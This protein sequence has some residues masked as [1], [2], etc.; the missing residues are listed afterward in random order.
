[1][2]EYSKVNF[3]SPACLIHCVGVLNVL[4]GSVAEIDI[5]PG[6]TEDDNGNPSSSALSGRSSSFDAPIVSKT[7][8]V[9]KI[10]NN[11][12]YGSNASKMKKNYYSQQSSTTT[13]SS[14]MKPVQFER[15][16]KSLDINALDNQNPITNS[17]SSNSFDKVNK[18]SN[19]V[20][21]SSSESSL[22]NHQSS[23][24]ETT[25]LAITTYVPYLELKGIS[26]I[27]MLPSCVD[28]LNREASLSDEEFYEVFG[29]EK[30]SFY[31]LPT[32]KRVNQK[33]AKL[34]F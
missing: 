31:K 22:N 15:K 4:E 14:S 2:Y 12:N 16:M 29:M 33:K 5:K 26:E 13:T 19:T 25:E 6:M 28:P 7:E 8:N 20:K 18:S 21:E 30:E 34:L 32:W 24:D 1:L 17:N 23:S 3:S 27:S 11:N 9:N 10:P